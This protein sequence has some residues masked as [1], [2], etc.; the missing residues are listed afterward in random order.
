[1]RVHYQY[2]NVN[3]LPSQKLFL[4]CFHLLDRCSPGSLRV[5]LWEEYTTHL[6]NGGNLICNPLYASHF[7]LIAA[8][9]VFFYKTFL[10]TYSHQRKQN[11]PHSPFLGFYAEPFIPLSAWFFFHPLAS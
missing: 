8:I 7:S 4:P 5:L 9:H 3:V 11:P 1:M 10:S 2:C 6:S